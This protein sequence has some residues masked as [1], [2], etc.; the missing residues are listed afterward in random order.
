M[1]TNK[2]AID[3]HHSGHIEFSYNSEDSHLLTVQIFKESGDGKLLCTS[4]T[5]NAQDARSFRNFLYSFD[6]EFQ[7]RNGHDD[8]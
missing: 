5:I 3:G 4:I 2:M 8:I 7:K 1:R 6:D